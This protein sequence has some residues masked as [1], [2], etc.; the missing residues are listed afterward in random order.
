[1]LKKRLIGVVT[2]KDG[3]A[4]QSFGYR[5]Y[6]P[7]GKPQCVIENL[8]R[9]GADEILV[10]VID[11]S[12]RDLGPDFGLLERIG[13]LGLETPLI[14]GG[15]IRSVADGVQLVQMGADRLLIDTLLHQD[16]AE[17][18]ALSKRLGA[19]A[20]IASLP[21]TWRDG[22]LAWHDYRARNDKPITAAL[23]QFLLSGV[24]SEALLVDWENEGTADG[25]TREITAEFPLKNMP[26]IAFGG[27]SNASRMR[28]LLQVPQI[29]AVA[30]GNF[31]NYREHAVQEYKSALTGLPVRQPTYTSEHKLLA[32]SDV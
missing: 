19:Q 32:G 28:E 26:L 9:W 5:R 20:L 1:M 7:L 24:L 23:E 12:A 11:R 2:I 27:L 17:V 15:G 30:V 10:Q 16:F 22:L 29:A 18:D 3:W 8:D 6:L 4:V 14:Y 25:F 21:L 31:L 13:K